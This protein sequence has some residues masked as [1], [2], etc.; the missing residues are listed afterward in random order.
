MFVFLVKCSG[1]LSSSGVI[2]FLKVGIV[3]SAILLEILTL[4]LYVSKKR[5]S[6]GVLWPHSESVSCWYTQYIH[7]K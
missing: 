6:P 7:N 3:Q 4:L 2:I 5:Q 1:K